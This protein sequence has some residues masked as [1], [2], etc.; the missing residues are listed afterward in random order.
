MFEILWLKEELKNK[1]FHVFLFAIFF[2][3]ISIII[4]QKFL[5]FYNGLVA[6]FIISL[7]AAYPLIRY[8]KVEEGEEVTLV[9]KFSEK[10]ILRR[11]GR[12]LGLYLSFFMGVLIVFIVATILLPDGFFKI[13]QETIGVIL[14]G[15]ATHGEFFWGILSNNLRVF[16]ITFL[17]SFFIS[18][19][20]IFILVWNA[21]ILGVFLASQARG[22][23]HIPVFSLGYLPHG[24]LEIS[25]YILAGLAGALISYNV[26]NLGIKKFRRDLFP[27]IL[28]DACVIAI[29]GLA[30]VL[31][32]AVV[33]V[34]F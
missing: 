16:G 17:I 19:G 11:H 13:Q 15:S 6:V 30:F 28:L 26:P 23:A 10:N 2:S 1:Y 18:A 20:M 4:T 24:L 27:K 14:S 25:A 5:N 29:I 8:M 9:K 3:T 32:G 12:E 22:I 21:S 7:A 34:F 31:I 33:E